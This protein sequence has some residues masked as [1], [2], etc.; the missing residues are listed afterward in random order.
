MELRLLFCLARR[1]ED[2]VAPMIATL[3][4]S[5]QTLTSATSRRSSPISKRAKSLPHPKI[6]ANIE[7]DGRISFP[8]R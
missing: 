8:L 3:L 1:S 4:L 7:F 2:H 5:P 6:M